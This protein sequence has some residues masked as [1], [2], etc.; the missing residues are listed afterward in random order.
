[1]TYRHLIKMEPRRH[2]PFVPGLMA[3]IESGNT[4]RAAVSYE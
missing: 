2:R 3:G 1:L 4:C